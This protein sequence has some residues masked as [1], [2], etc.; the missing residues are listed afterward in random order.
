MESVWRVLAWIRNNRVAVVITASAIVLTIAF[1]IFPAPQGPSSSNGS[2]VMTETVVSYIK[3]VL[4]SGSSSG[5]TTTT[6][7]ATQVPR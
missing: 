7:T 3:V 1:P 5:V 6:V 2:V 4:P